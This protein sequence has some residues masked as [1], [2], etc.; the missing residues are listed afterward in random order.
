MKVE[1]IEFSQVVDMW[2]KREIA[3]SKLTLRYFDLECL[4][5]LAV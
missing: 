3:E 2:G 4:D 1:V 5:G